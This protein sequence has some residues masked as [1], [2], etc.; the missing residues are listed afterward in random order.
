V[1]ARG[2]TWVSRLLFAKGASK[3]YL[4][5]GLVVDKAR[6]ILGDLEL[7]FLDLLAKLPGRGGIISTGVELDGRR[8]KGYAV[9]RKEHKGS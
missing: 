8:G 3:I 5:Q 7:A 2:F 6:R 1:Q 9:I 4:L